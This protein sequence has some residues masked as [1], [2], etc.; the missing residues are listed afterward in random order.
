MNQTQI[1]SLLGLANRAGK[2]VT[3]EDLVLKEIRNKRAKLVIIAEDASENTMKKFT[4]KCS[5]YQVPLKKV[6]SRVT[7]GQ[8]IG[9]PERVL[10]AVLDAGFAEK[11]KSL[12]D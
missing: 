9:K 8:S 2:I 10:V 1:Y 12:F 3:G 6:N 7:L 5:Y 4:D 11:L